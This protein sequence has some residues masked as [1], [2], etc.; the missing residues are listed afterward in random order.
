MSRPILDKDGD[1]VTEFEDIHDVNNDGILDEADGYSPA[2]VEY[3]D[4]V[5]NATDNEDI[6]ADCWGAL[7]FVV[8]NDFPDLLV[9]RIATSGKI[10]IVFSLAVFAL[11]L[12]I[13]GIL[14]FFIC[15]LLMLPGILSAQDVYKFF[16]RNSF[17]DDGVDVEK[18]EN[19]GE[20]HKAKIC[21]LALSQ[22][23]FARVV[24]F[25]WITTNVAEMKSIINRMSRVLN[26]PPLPQGLDLRLMV[27]DSE[28][29][30]GSVVCLNPGSKRTLMV[31]NYMPKL[32]IA[33][34]LT[35][36]GCLWLLA[37]ESIG[38]LILNSLAL[39]FVVQVDELLAQ[40]FFPFF[41]LEDLTRLGIASQKQCDDPEI[42]EAKLLKSFFWS[43]VQ[44]ALVT[45][46]VESMMRYQPVIPTFDHEVVTQAC[47]QYVSSQ[48]PWCMPGRTDC[49]PEA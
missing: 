18:F 14:L 35:V 30:G 48:V 33:I 2:M 16:M 34:L 45:G 15:K 13:Q 6:A 43:A 28:T 19:L 32:T 25:L 27:L 49:F 42:V 4:I 31:T 39:A 40:V 7:F 11:N 5:K 38:D 44:L 8:V 10:R 41:Y 26:L 37:A 29:D 1:G 20:E 24:L 9:G 3:N 12:F 21:G 46:V 47:L 36:T 17:S 22:P 23:I